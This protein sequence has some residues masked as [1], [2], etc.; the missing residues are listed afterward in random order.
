MMKVRRTACMLVG[1]AGMYYFDP[2]MG[3]RRRAAVRNKVRTELARRR[4]P[5]RAASGTPVPSLAFCGRGHPRGERSNGRSGHSLLNTASVS[6]RPVRA[7]H[8]DGPWAIAQDAVSPDSVSNSRTARSTFDGL[9]RRSGMVWPS[10]YR[11][12]T[13]G[14]MYDL[15]ATVGV[16]PSCSDT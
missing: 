13:R 1:A 11:S 14:S 6:R 4:S 2:S 9:A 3:R 16:L 5:E 12:T 10:S 7:K 8:S 15:R